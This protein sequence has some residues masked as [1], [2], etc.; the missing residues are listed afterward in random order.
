MLPGDGRMSVPAAPLL[1]PFDGPPEA[2][3]CRRQL[4]HPVA[5]AGLRPEVGEP[6]Q[7]ERSRRVRRRPA[8]A[9]LAEL[10]NLPSISAEKTRLSDTEVHIGELINKQVQGFRRA[11]IYD[12]EIAT[13]GSVIRLSEHL[14]ASQVEEI[15][16]VC[17]HGLFFGNALERLHAIPQIKK[18][19][20]TDTVPIPPEKQSPDLV[21]LSVAP[22][23]A[24][25]IHH[26]Y[27]RHSIGTLFDY[28]EAID[29][30]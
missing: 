9:R 12:D 11:I 5:P 7:V 18:I 22:L 25:A 17:T 19:I 14:I 3:T 29:D 2:V 21:I 24:E 20:T 8:A 26:N 28:G 1:H 23:I 16:L 6:E 4:H 15:Y 10:L 13:G 27:C 30:E